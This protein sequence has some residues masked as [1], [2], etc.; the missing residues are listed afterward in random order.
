[1]DTAQETIVKQATIAACVL[2]RGDQLALI[3]L[4]GKSD[5]VSQST[6]LINAGF[7]YHGLVGIVGGEVH[8]A[9][10]DELDVEC[11]FNMGR[12]ARM[13]GYLVPAP[14]SDGAEWLSRLYQLPDDRTD[15]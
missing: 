8:T 13:F 6:M 7:T 15:N 3:E 1:M 10:N 12:A 2:S 4:T 11:M 5:V 14:A 9:G